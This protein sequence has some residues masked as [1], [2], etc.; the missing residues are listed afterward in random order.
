MSDARSELTRAE[1]CNCWFP[2]DPT[3]PVHGDPEGLIAN[4]RNTA[5][6][7]EEA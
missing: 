3:C 7:Q 1:G 4:L 5:K 2:G 6:G